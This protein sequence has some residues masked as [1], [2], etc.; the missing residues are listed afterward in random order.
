MS[1]GSESIRVID[2]NGDFAERPSTDVAGDALIDLM[3]DP[4]ALTTELVDAIFA[5]EDF[6]DEFDGRYNFNAQLPGGTTETTAINVV[7]G[8][9]DEIVDDRVTETVTITDPDTGASI[10]V[11][12]ITKIVFQHQDEPTLIITLNLG[13]WA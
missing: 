6:Q 4:T 5:N 12:R 3:T 1:C 10:D 9:Y 13:P 7:G 8:E 11:E 2:E